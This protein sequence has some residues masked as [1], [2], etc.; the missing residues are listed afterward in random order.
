[1]AI[2]TYNDGVSDPFEGAWNL[3]WPA[4]QEA[5]FTLDSNMNHESFYPI[6]WYSLPD[7]DGPEFNDDVIEE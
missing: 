4:Y 7:P 3:K 1:M 2:R 6:L 5:V